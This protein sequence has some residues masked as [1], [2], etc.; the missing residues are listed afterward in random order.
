MNFQS[1]VFPQDMAAQNLSHADLSKDEGLH[2]FVGSR[3][4]TQA[5]GT[6]GGEGSPMV[7]NLVAGAVAI[8]T[9]AA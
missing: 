9:D 1:R 4:V 5:G 2:L 8:V 6:F 3:G 7:V